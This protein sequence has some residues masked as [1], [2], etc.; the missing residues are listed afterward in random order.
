MAWLF[1]VCSFSISFARDG[2]AA[3]A[4]GK[5]ADGPDA[6][7][8]GEYAMPA[9]GGVSMAVRDVIR[10]AVFLETEDPDRAERLLLSAR[11]AAQGSPDL[12]ALFDRELLRVRA[13]RGLRR[14]QQTSDGGV[15]VKHRADQ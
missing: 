2:A 3:T 9:D 5:K 13:E 10:R 6:G 14:V 12:V 11:P 4:D 8:R 15:S 7:P 1:A